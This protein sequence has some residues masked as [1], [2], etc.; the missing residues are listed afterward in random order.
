MTKGP[1]NKRPVNRHGGIHYAWVVLGITFIGLIVAAAVRSEPG[2]ILKSL[3]QEFGWSRQSITLSVSVNLLLFGLAGPF[4]GRLMDLYGPRSVAIT[5]VILIILGASGTLFIAESWHLLLL[6]GVLVGAGSGGMSMVLAS[7][8]VNRWF[9]KRR[10][11]ALGIAGAAMSAGQLIFT[12]I[13]MQ[14]NMEI[15]WRG[16]IAF[17]VMMLGIIVLPV[18]SIFMRDA[19]EEL[20]ILAYGA[21]EPVVQVSRASPNPMP[22]V[23]KSGQFWLLASS[24]ALCGLT[25]SG[26]FQT[27]LIPHGI[28]SGFSEMTMA[29]SLGLMGATDIVGT[30]ASGWICDAFGK[31]GPLAIYYLVRGASLIALPYVASVESLMIFSVVYGLNWLSTVPATS[32]LAADLFGKQNIGVVFGWIFFA[33]QLGAAIAAYGASYLYSWSGGYSIV[34]MLAGS[35]AIVATGIVLCIKPMPLK[36]MA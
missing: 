15:G 35:F 34:F 14:L 26:L 10:G 20:D 19:P 17:I 8:V 13:L 22:T 12:P 7:S 4:L 23:I 2:I 11:L 36:S 3:E 16:S 6:W 31:R 18:L 30:I 1:L 32:A 9:Y 29:F 33:H 24:F 5:T 21:I 27:H 25:T 28:E